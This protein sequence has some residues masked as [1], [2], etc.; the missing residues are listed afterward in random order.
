M[1]IRKQ[2]CFG[3][4]GASTLFLVFRHSRKTAAKSLRE[5]DLPGWNGK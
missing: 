4:D 5:Y 1:L 2:I 3:V